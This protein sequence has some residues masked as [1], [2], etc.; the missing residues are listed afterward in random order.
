MRLLR[1]S[2]GCNRRPR[3]QGGQQEKN[4]KSPHGYSSSLTATTSHFVLAVL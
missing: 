2:E 3:G 1:H 4:Q